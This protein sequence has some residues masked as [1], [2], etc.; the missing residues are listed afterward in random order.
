MPNISFN[1]E[2][3]ETTFSCNNNEIMKDIFQNYATR[4]NL[5]M[6]KLIFLYNGNE[7]NQEK[8]LEEIMNGFDKQRDAMNI[9]VVKVYEEVINDNII[10][11]EDIICP[12]CQE[13][14]FIE[15]KD[16]KIN[17]HGCKNGH[18]LYNISLEDFE[19]L[20][21]IDLSKIICNSCMTRNKGIIYN[22]EFYKCLTCNLDLCPDCKTGHHQQ[23]KIINYDKKNYV[24][25]L[26]KKNYVNFCEDCKENICLSCEASHKNHKLSYFGNIL[27][28]ENMNK[29][30]EEL[31]I[32][33]NSLNLTID[34][35]TSKLK[36]VKKSFGLYL[37]TF[38]NLIKIYNE[39]NSNYQLIKN[40]NEFINNNK[41]IIEQINK[42][43]N[44]IL[45]EKPSKLINIYYLMNKNKYQ[46]IIDINSNDNNTINENNI[47]GNFDIIID[48][49]SSSIK[50]GINTN[51]EEEEISTCIGYLNQNNG[52]KEY[53]IE[54]NLEQKRDNF[55][56]YYP[57]D[58]GIIKDWDI[59]EKLYDNIF[60]DK[61]KVNSSKHNIMITELPFNSKKNRENLLEYLFEVYDAPGVSFM[62]QSHLALYGAGKFDGLVV[63]L[64]DSYNHFYPVFNCHSNKNVRWSKTG[65][66]DITEF[67]YKSLIESGQ[68]IKYK[69][70]AKIL[71]EKACYVAFDYE[72]EIQ[73]AET[74]NYQLP[75]STV[76]NIKDLRF[77]CPE[78]LFNQQDENIAQISYNIIMN[79]KTWEEKKILVN[80]II[81]S[82][83]NSM[84]NGLPERFKIELKSLLP[85]SLKEEV[86]IIN[87]PE[88][89]NYSFTGG[90]ILTCISTFNNWIKKSI[91]EEEGKSIVHKICP[92]II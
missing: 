10:K 16:F 73:T 91:Y 3:V 82:G 15:L 70:Y 66:K 67:L 57:M 71:K 35:I 85:E 76:I 80:N 14:T 62:N 60:Y 12:K 24:C 48:N 78:L 9:L 44:S 88:R 45:F 77:K 53:F 49:G 2:G 26:H 61:L 20:Q 59:M 51:G 58:R 23:H 19:N 68:N 37:S 56:L 41:Y 36:K 64:G 43:K 1:C 39:E 34:E 5:D 22:N 86:H 33:I 8:N 17:L 13:N 79:C 47:E 4:E 31:K 28:D 55:E 84:F 75:D 63:D 69:E 30:L 6:K 65:G 21:N 27:P 7:I 38:D 89:K 25:N 74:I 11:S 50:Y 42:V 83:G 40:I 18:N 46:N 72:E 52:N 54:K 90:S 87:S 92:N 32:N 29:K 81:L